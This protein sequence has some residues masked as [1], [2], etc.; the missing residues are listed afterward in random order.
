VEMLTTNR[1]Y[2]VEGGNEVESTD[3]LTTNSST[4][5]PVPNENII[6]FYHNNSMK[7]ILRMHFLKVKN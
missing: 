7:T 5:L 6:P 1:V 2:P 3:Q 4:A